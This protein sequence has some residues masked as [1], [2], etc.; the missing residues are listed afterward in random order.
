MIQKASLSNL[1]RIKNSVPK[2]YLLV[3]THQNR[4]ADLAYVLKYHKIV[5]IQSTIV[6]LGNIALCSYKCNVTN[7]LQKSLKCFNEDSTNKLINSLPEE[8][9]SK[10][11]SYISESEGY[12]QI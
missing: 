8:T 2:G 7:N 4:L 9:I 6:E 12:Y 1:E 11:C 3:I 5:I 10:V